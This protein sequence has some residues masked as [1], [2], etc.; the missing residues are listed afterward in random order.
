MTIL[1]GMRKADPRRWTPRVLLGLFVVLLALSWWTAMPFL[2][3]VLVAAFLVAVLQ[4]PHQWLLAKLGGRKR[5]AAALATASVTIVLFLPLAVFAVAVASEVPGAIDS[6]RQWL[7]PDGLSALP[8]K[9]PAPLRP[10]VAGFMRPSQPRAGVNAANKE[11][12]KSA[13]N[14]VAP[15]AGTAVIRALDYLVLS[16]VLVIS[17]FY[18][19]LDGR[20]FVA[21]FLWLL[22]LKPSYA[23]ELLAEFWSV[24]YA[25]IWGTAAIA[26]GQGLGGGI[27]FALLGV[28]APLLLALG[29]AF[30]SFIPAIGTTLVWG[31]VAAWLLLS[32]HP[33][34]AAILVAYCM[35]VI[36]IFVD[37]L[38]RPMVVK[39]KM[40]MH[41]LL[42]FIAMFGGVV[43]F[44]LIGLLV[45]PL[46]MSGLVTVLR[47]Y[48][49]DLGPHAEVDEKDAEPPEQKPA[50]GLPEL[51]KQH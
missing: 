8:K 23:T 18:L 33:G 25:M 42:A 4:R 41:P 48:Q 17:L 28:P 3:A 39:D 40:T 31:P 20:S 43:A 24:A 13:V 38:M 30:A 37:H 21:W 9:M 35:V 19:F 34:K 27:I 12:V 22:P 45:G 6:A 51:S 1:G 10:L 14:A 11:H 46:V 15:V 2:P 32:G 44:G 50:G 47:I 26:L 7:G 5:T 49:R 16:L 29:M 36:V